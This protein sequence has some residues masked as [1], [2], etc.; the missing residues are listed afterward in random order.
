MP[1]GILPKGMTLPILQGTLR[2]KKWV[3]GSSNHGCWLGS[4]E[5]EKQRLFERTVKE[6]FTV[7]DVGAHVGFYTLLAS[8]LV[9]ATGKVFAFEPL[10]RN[11]RYLREHLRRNHVVNVSVVEAAVSDRSGFA[12]FEEGKGHS[13][14]HLAP[15]GRL[16]VRTVTLDELVFQDGLPPPNCIKIDIEGAEM[17]AL[18]GAQSL[19]SNYRPSI[20]LATHGHEIHR[21]CCRFL[22]SLKY[23]L[24]SIGRTSLDRA[25]EIIALGQESCPLGAR[26]GQAFRPGQRSI[27]S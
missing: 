18:T 19:L 15:G 8:A 4:Y 7:F 3:V 27:A 25:D 16:R 17:L 11:L 9:G 12:F 20:F 10:P 24:R 22:A 5:Y 23:E 6:G 13:T 21:E 1:L 26:G 2:G 14:G